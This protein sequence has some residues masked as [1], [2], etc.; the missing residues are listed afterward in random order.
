MAFAR[1]CKP[2]GLR[3]A[4]ND[5]LIMRRMSHNPR[6]PKRRAVLQGMGALAAAHASPATGPTIKLRLLETSD[7]HTFDED[8]DYSRD[9]PDETVGLTKVATLIHAARAGARNT[10]LFDN[11]DIIQGNPLADYVAIPGQFPAD[12]TRPTIRAMNT[13]GYDAATVG[14][15]EF[16]YG[17]DFCTHP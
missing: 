12:G 8:Y 6:L 16:N 4:V 10:L 5:V 11:G 17:L 3:G 15:H 7:L 2:G 1:V 13:L 9:Q 14:N